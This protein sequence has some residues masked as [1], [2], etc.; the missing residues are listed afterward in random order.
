M[1]RPYFCWKCQNRHPAPTGRGCP[2]DIL[3]DNLD[4]EI[5]DINAHH[6]SAMGLSEVA[7]EFA[8]ASDIK[9]L[10]SRLDGL[11]TLLYKISENLSHDPEVLDKF[12]RDS[13]PSK[14][15]GSSQQERGRSPKKH[16]R[17]RRRDSS[18][19]PSKLE[20]FSYDLVFDD[21]DIKISSFSQIMVATFRNL[22]TMYEE[23]IDITSLLHHGR[24][25]SEK[26]SADV[27]VTE[28][29]TG[30]DKFARNLANRKGPDVF[31]KISEM[32]KNRFFSLENYKEVR[33]F[34]SKMSKGQSKK[35][36]V[37]RH[38]NGE[39]GCW[40]KGC[41]YTH[42]CLACGINGHG[43]FGCQSTKK[44]SSSK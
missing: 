25:M 9:D 17:S 1:G 2:V 32:D 5:E 40:A 33:A 11:E 34:K 10:S 4:Q 41:P 16:S 26:S 28:A 39:N 31:G 13:S 27:Y 35:N 38:F 20:P 44:A 12:D 14:S 43:A 3:D 24:F 36:G 30:F 29:F 23:G 42:K 8:S 21:D 19:S 22:I 7:G 15:D 6:S 18:R 37:C